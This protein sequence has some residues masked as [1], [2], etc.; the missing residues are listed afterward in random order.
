MTGLA[1]PDSKHPL[2]VVA[3]LPSEVGRPA[4]A[5]DAAGS[6]DFVVTAVCYPLRCV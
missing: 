1:S 4:A 3:G 2:A 6:V 5:V